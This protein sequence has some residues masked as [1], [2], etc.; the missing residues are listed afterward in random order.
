MNANPRLLQIG[1]S[2]ACAIAVLTAMAG[3]P[4]EPPTLVVSQNGASVSDART[5]LTWAR[6]VEGMRWDGRTCTGKPRLLTHAEALRQGRER[7]KQESLGWRLP[8]VKEL[9]RLAS[10]TAESG[11]R[12]EVL[13][14]ASPPDWY[15]TATANVESKAVNPYDY[16]N[17]E[18]GITAQNANS[19]AFLLAWAVN[20]SSG[21]ARGDVLKRMKL[22]VRLV[23]EEGKAVGET[24]RGE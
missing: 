22:P 16:K 9:Q 3:A 19:M 6:C 20:M 1:T 15:W 24:G 8:R 18:R 21:A 10:E 17:I 4:A 14:P 23:R 13:F 5:K 7:A 12:S 11:A 2:L